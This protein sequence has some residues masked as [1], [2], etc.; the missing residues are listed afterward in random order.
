MAMDNSHWTFVS[1]GVMLPTSDGGTGRQGGNMSVRVA[2]YQD[3]RRQYRRSTRLRV[4]L[5]MGVVLIVGGTVSAPVG[6][7]SASVVKAHVSLFTAVP[8][9][10]DANGEFRG[11]TLTLN[12]E[13][14]NAVSC[15]FSGNNLPGLPTTVD[16]SAGTASVQIDVPY[17]FSK[18][19]KPIKIKVTARDAAGGGGSAGSTTQFRPPLPITGITKVV[20]NGSSHC[21]LAPPD[22][23]SSGGVY[24]WGSNA[25]G[26][27]GLASRTG[28]T[29]VARS[30]RGVNNVGYL[31]NVTD[32]VNTGPGYCALLADQSVVCWGDNT[33]GQLGTGSLVGP[34]NCGG[35]IQCSTTPVHVDT[36]PRLVGFPGVTYVYDTTVSSI[37]GLGSGGGAC[38]VM[39]SGRALCWGD[40][41]YGELGRGPL[42]SG[43]ACAPHDCSPSV[44]YVLTGG[45]IAGPVPLD[46]IS[47]IVSEPGDRN[48]C[49]LLVW[50]YPFCWG[51]NETGQ[52]G[53]GS[54]DPTVNLATNVVG[55]IGQDHL[56]HVLQL[57]GQHTQSLMDPHNADA[58]LETFGYCARLQFGAIACWGDNTLGQLGN[59]YAVG[60]D[61]CNG[62]S[63]SRV[64][65]LVGAIGGG[66]ALLSGTT[67]LVSGPGGYCAVLPS[68]SVACWGANVAGSLGVGNAHPPQSC[69]PFFCSDLPMAVQGVTKVTDLASDGMTYC[70]RVRSGASL[71]CWGDDQAG[72][73][74]SSASPPPEIDQPAT[75]LGTGGS[76]HLSGVTSV[77][78]QVTGS[79][80]S[81]FCAVVT[82]GGVDCWGI[83]FLGQV[84]DGG[85]VQRNWPTPVGWYSG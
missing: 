56:Y 81:S 8:S 69:S 34:Q 44:D 17:N 61:T 19:A 58:G 7:A 57:V 36:S 74:G 79:F 45:T 9:E 16:C 40:N 65:V 83:G 70:A 4:G 53:T 39:V 68:T 26:Q 72:Q 24:C 37:V 25:S 59:G 50:G 82:G 22:T 66:A 18:R 46:H 31:V 48:Y 35:N 84:G 33:Y 73:V 10:T 27:T 32:I 13:V 49:A 47:Q 14:T 55:V 51:N 80:T 2:K 78:N 77:S 43:A 54:T 64:P 71:A 52:L 15:T 63:C 23:L 67:D 5:A 62:Y 41:F 60:P 20:G 3:V 11:G 76:G 6:D 29:L 1:V 85:G 12:V 75:V 21:A 42:F 30:V 28:L 38:A